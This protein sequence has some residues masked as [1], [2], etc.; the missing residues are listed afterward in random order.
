MPDRLKEKA[1]S[2]RTKGSNSKLKN[3]Y[4]EP[5][6]VLAQ[7]A[8]SNKSIPKVSISGVKKETDLSGVD[9]KWYLRYMKKHLQ[10][11]RP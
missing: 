7:K 9:S 3:V 5:T 8:A 10:Q 4:C 11:K 1:P 6:K 2:Y